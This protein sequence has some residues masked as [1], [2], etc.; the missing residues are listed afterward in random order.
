MKKPISRRE[1]LRLATTGA[2]V[3]A[4][5]E[6]LAACGVEELPPT[7]TSVPTDAPTQPPTQT[8]EPTLTQQ[9]PSATP[10]EVTVVEVRPTDTSEP[11]RPKPPRWGRSRKDR[12]VA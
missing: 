9:P 7:L 5:N 8:T 3:L 11:S 6:L 12:A 10:E 4:L 1:F 2:G